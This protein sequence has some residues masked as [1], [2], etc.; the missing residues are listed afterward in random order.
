MLNRYPLV[1]FVA[2]AMLIVACNNE[3]PECDGV[4]FPPLHCQ[5][6]VKSGKKIDSVNIYMPGIDSA[7]HKG[8]SMPSVID[9]PLNMSGD[10]TFVQ[11]TIIGVTKTSVEKECSQ[12]GIVSCPELHIVNLECGPVYFFKDLSYTLFSMYGYEHVY[13]VDTVRETVN[14]KE[15]VNI[16]KRIVRD[17]LVN[18]NMAIDS[19]VYMTT[20]VDQEKEVN[21]AI[22]F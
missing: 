10:T 18:Y 17:T 12:L 6:E 19:L 14:G 1:A 16:D 4:E 20:E 3:P 15:Y 11:F 9:I 5:L 13:E 22:Y 8:K 7:L 21:A 2:L